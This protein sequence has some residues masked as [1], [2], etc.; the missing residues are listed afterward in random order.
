MHAVCSAVTGLS[1]LSWYLGMACFVRRL[2]SVPLPCSQLP[3]QTDIFIKFH[4]A[5]QDETNKRM[6]TDTKAI[7][8]RYLR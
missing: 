2:P 6:V 4:L 8:K 5:Y 7:A 1:L 3:A